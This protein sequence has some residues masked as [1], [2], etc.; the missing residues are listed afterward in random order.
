[1]S[2]DSENAAEKP[3]E[4]SVV[5]TTGPWKM[6]PALTEGSDYIRIC[7][8]IELVA[9]VGSIDHPWTQTVAD[10]RLIAAA[11]NLLAACKRLMQEI[12]DGQTTVYEES[13][14]ACELID[15]AIKRAS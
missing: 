14:I 10:A 3:S 5:H 4:Q 15:A 9:K 8:G 11:P 7:A 6:H 2:N 12:A 13:G 1:M